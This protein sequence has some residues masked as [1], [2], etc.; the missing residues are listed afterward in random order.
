MVHNL[1]TVEGAYDPQTWYGVV[2]VNG[3]ILSPERSLRVYSHSPDGFAWGY[4]GSGPAQL[5]LALLLEAGLGDAEAIELHQAF[6]WKFIAPV[7]SREP[8]TLTIDVD[9]WIK[10]ARLIRR[11]QGV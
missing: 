7:H 1:M 9:D 3:M 5:A 4:G 8:L 10:E 2:R 6:K 11:Q